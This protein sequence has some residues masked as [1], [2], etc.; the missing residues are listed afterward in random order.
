MCRVWVIF[1]DPH[2]REIVFCQGAPGRQ[3][4][5]VHRFLYYTTLLLLCIFADLKL[6]FMKSRMR[7][8][9]DMCMLIFVLLFTP[10]ITVLKVLSI[11][12]GEK[13]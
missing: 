3:D 2:P 10:I 13:Q 4:N 11:W 9:R 1:G 5:E 6:I 7:F 12:R 8:P